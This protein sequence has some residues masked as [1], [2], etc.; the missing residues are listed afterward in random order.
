[1]WVTNMGP[2][3][4]YWKSHFWYICS[5]GDA[6]VIKKNMALNKKNLASLESLAL[7]I[8][9][10]TIFITFQFDLMFNFLPWT[11]QVVL[12]ISVTSPCFDCWCPDHD[13]TIAGTRGHFYQWGRLIDSRYVFKPMARCDA[14]TTMSLIGSHP[15]GALVENGR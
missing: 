12:E 4:K 13:V 3:L 9:I 11:S 8:L 10:D 15:F 7:S 2:N 14:M 5:L 1:M 6:N